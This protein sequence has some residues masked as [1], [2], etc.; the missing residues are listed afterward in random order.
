MGDT[1][2]ELIYDTVSE[3]NTQNQAWDLLS[4]GGTLVIILP[5]QVD[6]GKY[7]DKTLID[8]VFGNVHAPHARQL[9]IS[10][11]SKLSSLLERGAVKVRTILQCVPII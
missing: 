10:L 5:P 6:K 3:A 9:G 2:I 4:P 8:N 7:K 11:Y 1:P